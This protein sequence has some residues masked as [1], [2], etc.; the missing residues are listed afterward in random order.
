M[1]ARSADSRSA[2]LKH[3]ADE[4]A[5]RPEHVL[6]DIERRF[7]KR[8]GAQMIGRAMAGGRRTAISGEQRASASPAERRREQ[9]RRCRIKADQR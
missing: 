1:R 2:T 9:R 8:R 5:A 3:F 4:N 7:E 6:G